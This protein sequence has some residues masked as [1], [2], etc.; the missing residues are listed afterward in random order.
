MVK[1]GEAYRKCHSKGY[2]SREPYCVSWNIVL[3][4]S[5]PKFGQRYCSIP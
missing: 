3:V 4:H 5:V 1:R 2:K